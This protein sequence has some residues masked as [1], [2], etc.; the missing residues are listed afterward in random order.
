MVSFSPFAGAG[1]QFFANDGAPLAGG[2]LYTYVAGTTTPS[3]VYTSSSGATAHSN[4][5]ILNSA[6]RVPSEIWLTVRNTYKFVLTSS[7]DVVIG[8]YD[9][10]PAATFDGAPFTSV[11][12]TEA[13]TAGNFVNIYSNSGTAAVR[14]ASALDPAKYANGFVLSSVSSG[15][16]ATVYSVGINN[17]VTVTV[18]GEVWLSDATPGAFVTTP[19]S[20]SNSIVQPL[21]TAVPGSGIFFTL[22]MRVQL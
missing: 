17:A 14:K 12:A 22:Q 5:I 1:W 7:V 9:N 15:S 16:G 13:L 2:K 6:G 4:P 10:I 3:T 20:A 18:P 11:N 8:T 21:G 19:P